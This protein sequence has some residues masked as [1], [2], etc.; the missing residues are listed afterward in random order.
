MICDSIVQCP[1]TDNNNY[2]ILLYV[3]SLGCTS[4]RTKLPEWRKLILESDTLFENKPDFLFFFQPRINGLTDLE[5]LLMG[6]GFN[7]PVFVDMKNEIMHLNNFPKEPEYQC[8]LLDKE[9]KV[10]MVG[11]PVYNPA[12]WELYKKI[13]RKNGNT[14]ER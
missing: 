8:F 6:N 7:Y 3:D 13:I 4:C 14:D 9:N 2:K 10:V 5:V 1:E 11:N 12:I